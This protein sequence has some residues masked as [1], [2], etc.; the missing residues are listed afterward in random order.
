MTKLSDAW[1]KAYISTSSQDHSNVEIKKNFWE[2]NV[3][4]MS[5]RLFFKKQHKKK[6]K[7]K[8]NL[9]WPGNRKRSQYWLRQ[10][11]C[12]KWQTWETQWFRPLHAFFPCSCQGQW[13]SGPG[14]GRAQLCSPVR[15]GPW[16]GLTAVPHTHSLDRISHLLMPN[17][18]GDTQGESG[19]CLRRIGHSR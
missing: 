15:R 11:Y 16:G 17:R 1:T 9:R 2:I 7:T 19:L 5:K 18:Q 8:Q 4:K 10:C 6:R 13:A 3:V 12:A 14:A